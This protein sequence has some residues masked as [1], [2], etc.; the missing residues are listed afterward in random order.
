MGRAAAVVLSGRAARCRPSPGLPSRVRAGPCLATGA[1]PCT[2]LRGSI[3]AGFQLD[4][5][6][7]I[8]DV[9]IAVNS[10]NQRDTLRRAGCAGFVSPYFERRMAPNAVRRGGMRAGQGREGRSTRRTRV[11][12]RATP[13]P[14]RRRP[15]SRGARMRRSPAVGRARRR[16]RAADAARRVPPIGGIAGRRAAAAPAWPAQDRMAHPGEHGAIATRYRVGIPAN[17]RTRCRIRPC[18]PVPPPPPPRLPCAMR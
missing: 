5:L 10:E 1:A 3:E 12:V 11:Q 15:W 4:A 14:R 18:L 8:S 2:G 16:A 9:S 6:F 17:R 13:W 7:S